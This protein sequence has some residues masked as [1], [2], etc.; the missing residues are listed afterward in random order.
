MRV[1]VREVADEHTLT[2][3]LSWIPTSSR[4]LDRFL[5]A[6]VQVQQV[7]VWTGVH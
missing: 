1:L 4:T 7:R 2:L 6:A 5:D 3:S